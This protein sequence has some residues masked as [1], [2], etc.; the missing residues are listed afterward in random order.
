MNKMKFSDLLMDMINRQNYLN[1]LKMGDPR[2]RETMNHLI[3]IMADIDEY[4][5]GTVSNKTK[6]MSNLKK[7]MKAQELLS[8]VY[9]DACETGNKQLESLMSAADDCVCEAVDSLVQDER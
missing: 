9:H 2:H 8:D 1:S 6:P 5:A 7:L 4:M 3:D